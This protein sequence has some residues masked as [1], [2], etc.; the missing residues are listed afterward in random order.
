MPE[1]L[2]STIVTVTDNRYFMPVFILILSLKY[3]KVQSFIKILGVQ[4]S[5]EQKKLY[6]QFENV[7]V[8]DA[9]LTNTRN[10]ATRKAEA[11]LLAADDAVETISLLDG[12][13]IATG[14]ITKYLTKDVHGLSVRAKSRDEDGVNFSKINRYGADDEYGSIPNTI[15]KKWQADVC[16]RSEPRI[17]NTVCGGN[18][19]VK[20]SKL[21][22]IRCWHDQMMAVLPNKPVKMAYDYSDF[23]YFQ[24]DESVLNSL[25]A[26]KHTV[27]TISSGWFDKDPDAYVAHLGPCNP[28]YWIFWRRDRLRYFDQVMSLITWGEAIYHFPKK[29]WAL[30][31]ENKYLI[32]IAS[33]I[34]E[35]WVILKHN[36]SK[37]R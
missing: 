27:P 2:N 37:M 6:E 25:L 3:H 33:Y 11:I 23:A 21:D 22:F 10:P 5:D 15:L 1:E 36:L 13:C 19:T 34:Y 26:Y 17:T 28:R 16:E 24:M 18:L 14:D 29:T 32:Y 4:L 9:D 31:K 30:K 7:E 20:K 35:M 12:D 8:F